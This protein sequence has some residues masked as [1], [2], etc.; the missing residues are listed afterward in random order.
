MSE[1]ETM[2]DTKGQRERRGDIGRVGSIKLKTLKFFCRTLLKK[3][4]E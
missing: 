2:G 3:S 1:G 4:R